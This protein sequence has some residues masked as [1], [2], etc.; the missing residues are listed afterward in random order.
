MSLFGKFLMVVCVSQIL[1]F[2]F[3]QNPSSYILKKETIEKI[4]TTTS[5]EQITTNLTLDVEEEVVIGIPTIVR[6]NGVDY[7]IF[8]IEKLLE[9]LSLIEK[10]K[11]KIVILRSLSLQEASK[12]RKGEFD[13]NATRNENTFLLFKNLQKHF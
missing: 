2:W 8:T 6:P 7:L 5:T 10:Q 1:F 3:I 12:L 13:P 9:P 4:I 11:T